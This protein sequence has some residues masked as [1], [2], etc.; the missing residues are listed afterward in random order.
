[1]KL[2]ALGRLYRAARAGVFL[3]FLAA[4]VLAIPLTAPPRAAGY[5]LLFVQASA[6]GRQ[7][8][9]QQQLVQES[10]EAAGEDD[11]A[12]FKHSPS[13]QL[14]S[15]LTG[16]SLE[17]AYWLCV[18]LNFLVI[19]LVI[20]WLSKKNL[21]GM[22]RHRT[23]SIQNAMA[24]ARK[25]SE[26]ANRRLAGIES[27]LSRLDSEIAEMR[28]AAEQE[29][30]AEEQRIKAAAEDDARRI[31]TAAEQEITAVARAA[32]REL[33]AYAADLAVSL[34][35]KQIQIDTSTDQRLI[36]NFA[37]QLQTNGDEKK[38]GN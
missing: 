30:A 33:K 4:A 5:N 24:E 16:L 19:A 6:P 23:A 32:R 13:V 2:R 22:F 25:A 38:G 14:V 10:R 29:A 27:R 37:Q 15:R 3:S 8:S 21:P 34:A 7:P 1:M 18:L 28:A 20:V 11:A 9:T 35:R 26:E 31:V 17:H 36:H 12:Q